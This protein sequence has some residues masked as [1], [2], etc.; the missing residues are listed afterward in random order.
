MS[1]LG[2]TLG[3]YARFAR[4][5]MILLLLMGLARFFTGLSGVPYDR[6]T[7]LVSLTILSLVLAVVYGQKAAATGFGG[8]RQLLPT[9]SMLSVTMYGFIVLA[10]LVEGLGGLHGYFHAPGSGLAPAGMNM[11]THIGGQLIGMLIFTV[12]LWAVS[13]LAFLISRYLGFLR[14]AFLLLLAMAVLRILVGASGLP[15]AIGT[16]ITS[17][18][19]LAMALSIYFGYRA[20][21]SGFTSY[22]QMIIVGVLIA[23]AHTLLVVYGITVTTSLMIPNYFHSPGEGF[24]PAGMSIG[25]HIRGHLQVSVPGMLLMSLLALTGFALGRRRTTTPAGQ[26][27]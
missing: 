26:A 19:L 24:Q 6:A 21:G 16:W 22:Y 20:P 10:I 3:E 1:L 11:A 17:L 8:Y 23:V 13:S 15:Y 4:T 27:A 18:T 2:K 14:N 5:G 9:I 7:H 25:Q 12:E